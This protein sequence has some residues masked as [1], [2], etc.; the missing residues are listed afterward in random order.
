MCIYFF[1]SLFCVL[2]YVRPLLSPHV[3][4]GYIFADDAAAIF[5]KLCRAIVFPSLKEKMFIMFTLF[6]RSSINHQPKTFFFFFLFLFPN[7]FLTAIWLIS[8]SG[9][10][11]SSWY[12]SPVF[13]SP[14]KC[15]YCYYV[16]AGRCNIRHSLSLLTV[17]WS[18]WANSSIDCLRLIDVNV[19]YFLPDVVYYTD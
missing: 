14:L 4:D 11:S 10:L 17:I 8:F 15:Y 7:Q 2:F 5:L 19:I 9:E 3:L 13:F 18:P 6:S 12:S 16:R 1:L